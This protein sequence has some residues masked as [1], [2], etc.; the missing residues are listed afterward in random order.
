MKRQTLAIRWLTVL[1]CLLALPFVTW[2]PAALVRL[3]IAVNPN[4]RG[5]LST[6]LLY[7]YAPVFLASLL[8]S[9]MTRYL[10][11][12]VAAL[13]LAL[14]VLALLVARDGG[15]LCRRAR[16]YLLIAC[17]M[18]VLAFP[19]AFR[20][21]PAVEAAPGIEM[22]IVNESGLLE[23]AV[24]SCQASAEVYT[25]VYVPMGWADEH[26]LVYGVYTCEPGPLT[27]QCGHFLDWTGGDV[28]LWAYDVETR[29]TVPY[30]GDESSLTQDTCGLYACIKPRLDT[31]WFFGGRQSPDGLISP[32][33]HWIAFTARH[34][35]GP[36]DLLIISKEGNTDD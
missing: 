9:H 23:G 7:L 15:Q 18:S 28:P 35:Y 12:S 36:E 16:F 25:E 20:Y 11:F 21:R 24:R 22:H 26:T 19:L 33:G 29:K 13:V 2:I 34:V 30:T 17:T 6:L 4:P 1:V 32:G 3:V 14:L 5:V 27:L 31:G 8:L 10:L